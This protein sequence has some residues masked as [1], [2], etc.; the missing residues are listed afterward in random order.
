MGVNHYENFPVASL[1]LPP[2]FRHPVA[3]IYR[4]A[5]EADDF[6]D[7]GNDPAAQRI[8]ALDRYRAELDRIERGEGPRLPLFEELDGIVREHQLPLALFRDLLDAFTQDV[9]KGRYANYG[10]V[11]DYCRRSANPIGRLLLHLFDRASGDN[12]VWSD[13]ICSALQLINFWQDV[14]IDYAK[15]RIYLPQDEMATYGVTERHV[16]EQRCDGNWVALMRFQVER[17]RALLQSGASLGTALPGRIG[18]E[19]R[20]TVQGGLRILEKIETA[21]YDVFRQRPVLRWRDWPLIL[22]RAL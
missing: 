4:F 9:T 13:S 14:P 8:A 15:N 16:A 2:R 11:L 19:I 5:R 17:A 22:A 3:Q 7:E 20:V 12:P 6:A 18:L 21:R 1:L 10:E